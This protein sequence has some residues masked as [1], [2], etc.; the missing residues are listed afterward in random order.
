MSTDREM[1]KWEK[2][3]MK[4]TK[5][6]LIETLKQHLEECVCPEGSVCTF[7]DEVSDRCLYGKI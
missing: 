3:M 2:E 4:L 1:P 5:A 7:F 6:Q